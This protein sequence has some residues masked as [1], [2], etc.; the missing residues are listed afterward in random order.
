MIRGVRVINDSD[1]LSTIANLAAPGTGDLFDDIDT[2]FCDPSGCFFR[3]VRTPI[4]INQAVLGELIAEVRE[5]AS[6]LPAHE[7]V[8]RGEMRR[9]ASVIELVQDDPSERFARHTPAPL[10][11]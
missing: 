1:E 3:M 8:Q 10:F 5:V 6:Y 11:V 7:R 9:M 2:T 4:P